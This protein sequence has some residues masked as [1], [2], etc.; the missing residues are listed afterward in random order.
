MG[1]GAIGAAECSSPAY[2][3]MRARS[4]SSSM[5]APRRARIEAWPAQLRPLPTT[6]S[7]TA[8]PSPQSSQAALDGPSPG[9]QLADFGSQV[10]RRRDAATAGVFCSSAVCELV[11][12]S[13]M[14]SLIVWLTLPWST[15]ASRL[16]RPTTTQSASARRRIG[17]P[18]QAGGTMSG[19]AD[20]LM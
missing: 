6:P 14:S 8:G 17:D 10:D 5:V 7:F 1:Q 19:G 20:T 4:A 12:V 13:D 3:S 16:A 11:M 9:L 15:T 2:M 18:D